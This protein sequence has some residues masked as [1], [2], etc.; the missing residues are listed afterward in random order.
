MAVILLLRITKAG[1]IDGASH[2]YIARTY[3]MSDITDTVQKTIQKKHVN[4]KKIE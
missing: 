3:R 4:L 2:T 1:G